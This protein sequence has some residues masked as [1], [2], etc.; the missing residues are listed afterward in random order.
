MKGYRWGEVIRRIL[1]K[2][3]RGRPVK[4]GPGYCAYTWQVSCKKLIESYD[5]ASINGQICC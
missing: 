2:R 1:M 5:L 3:S 4:D